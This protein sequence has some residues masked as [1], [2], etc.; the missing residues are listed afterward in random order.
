MSDT[1]SQGT[2][3]PLL[4]PSEAILEAFRRLDRY[5]EDVIDAETAALVPPDWLEEEDGEIYLQES[6]MEAFQSL[7]WTSNKEGLYIYSD[8]GF[9]NGTANIVQ[10]LLSHDT[11]GA[12]CAT[13]EEAITT[14]KMLP[15]G[16]GGVAWFITPTAIE[17]FSTHGWLMEKQAELS[18]CSPRPE[19]VEIYFWKGRWASADPRVHAHLDQIYRECPPELVE[20][21]LASNDEGQDFVMAEL[22]RRLS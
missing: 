6:L 22:T 16:F 10:W 18:A 13:I 9:E 11:A 5:T 19:D 2:V 3:S 15:G 12:K 14:S 1:F 8:V 17:C 20:A 7:C 4:H 21:L